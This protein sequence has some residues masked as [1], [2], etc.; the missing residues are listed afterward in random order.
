MWAV[1]LTPDQAEYQYRKSDACALEQ[2]LDRVEQRAL[3]GAAAAA[4]LAPLFQDSARLVRSPH[5][6]DH[7]NRLLPGSRYTAECLQR[8]RED[9]QG[10]TLLAPL[11]LAG[12]GLDVIYARDLHARDTL[13]VRQYPGRSLYLLRPPTTAEGAEPRFYPLS[14][15]SLLTTWRR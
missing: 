2:A 5:T 13:L 4:E 15:D 9:S 6:P 14:R 10:F 7:T 8:L 3:R 1:G 12:R 11:A